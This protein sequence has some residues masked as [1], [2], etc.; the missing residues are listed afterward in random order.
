MRTPIQMLSVWNHS[1]LIAFLTNCYEI[2]LAISRA[3]V[4]PG[5]QIFLASQ[6]ALVVKNLPAN[7]GDINNVS[8][9][10]GLERFPGGGHGNSLQCLSLRIPWTEKPGGLQSKGLQRVGCDWSDLACT[11]LLWALSASLRLLIFLPAWFQL[12]IHLSWHFASCTLHRS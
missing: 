10:P 4:D 11:H 2:R 1:L 8:S 3:L 7:G 6:V 12:V 9:I 5:Y